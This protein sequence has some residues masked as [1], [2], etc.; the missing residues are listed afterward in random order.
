MEENIGC[1]SNTILIPR[2]DVERKTVPVICPRCNAITGVVKWHVE[3]N[4]KTSP[5][6][7]ICQSFIHLFSRGV[8]IAGMRESECRRLGEYYRCDHGN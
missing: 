5:V 1:I 2:T 4:R 3:R 8:V 6:Y 7:M